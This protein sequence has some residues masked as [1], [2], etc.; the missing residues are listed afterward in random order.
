[1]LQTIERLA[2]LSVAR[3]CGFAA[4]AIFTMMI[5]LSPDPVMAFETGGTLCLLTCAVLLLKARNAP[6]RP[7]NSTELWV[8]IPKDQ[9]P[10]RA[11]AQRLIGGVL[12]D[13]YY[14]FAWHAAMSA[15][16][17]L[18]LALLL[19]AVGVKSRPW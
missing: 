18:A 19:A 11:T 4:L 16:M 2:Q 14:R 12:Q 7:Y 13:V 15:A 8:I 3:G 6:R 17:M 9:R 1:M 5:G 10:E